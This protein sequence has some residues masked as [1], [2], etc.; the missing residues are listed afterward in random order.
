[1]PPKDSSLDDLPEMT[2]TQLLEQI[3]LL[4]KDATEKK[5]AA[6][7]AIQNAARALKEADNATNEMADKANKLS[8]GAVNAIAQMIA[9]AEQEAKEAIA[10]T[11]G[12]TTTTTATATTATATS[13]IDSNESRTVVSRPPPSIVRQEP[14]AALLQADSN[15]G[16]Q[17]PTDSS[18]RHIDIAEATLDMLMDKL[19]ECTVVLSNPN[20]TVEEHMTAAK[21]AREYA[22]AAKAFNTM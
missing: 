21:L 4:E 9:V 11:T 12:R 5:E 2:Q 14:E 16:M 10:T 6:D 1:M 17:D 3:A 13:Q 18:V 7:V 19:E 20:A 22:K 8:R 15:L